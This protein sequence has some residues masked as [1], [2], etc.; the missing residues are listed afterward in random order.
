MWSVVSPW[1]VSM[2]GGPG[3]SCVCPCF[4]MCVCAFTCLGSC[5]QSSRTRVP[6]A[7]RKAAANVGGIAPLPEHGLF[8]LPGCPGCADPGHK[9]YNEL[10]HELLSMQPTP[11]LPAWCWVGF[12]CL[13]CLNPRNRSDVVAAA[14]AAADC[15]HAADQHLADPVGHPT[16]VR[17]S[18]DVV[19]GGR[20]MNDKVTQWIQDWLHDATINR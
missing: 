11:A 3:R 2:A 10:C 1:V 17:D 6:K 4:R 12:G 7:W 9:L 14:L 13:S 18:R 20:G 19:G 5:L 15:A 8:P 16:W